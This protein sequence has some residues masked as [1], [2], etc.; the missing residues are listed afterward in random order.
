MITKYPPSF[1]GEYV[2]LGG[3]R[4]A[5]AELFGKAERTITTYTRLAKV[6][7]VING[8]SNEFELTEELALEFLSK[9]GK[10]VV[11]KD[12]DFIP[13]VR[14][15]PGPTEK[16]K[17]GIVSDTHLC[18]THQ[19]LTHLWD[20]YNQARQDGVKY[21]VHGGDMLAGN[22]VYTGQENE[23]FKW[24]GDAQVDY[25]IDKYPRFD[26]VTTY[27]IDG[28]HDLSFYAQAGQDIGRAIGEKRDDLVFCGQYA[29]MVNIGGL[30]I[31][32]QHGERG[33][34]YAVSYK[35]QKY[36]EQVPS[37]DKPHIVVL[38]HYHQAL[39]LP[40]YRNIIGILPGCFESQTLFL[41]RKAINPVIQGIIATFTVKR[42]GEKTHIERVQ[43]EFIP[44]YRP[45]PKDF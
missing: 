30:K 9:Q 5:L 29:G 7:G 8:K 16:I 42:K 28:N 13:T 23:I 14:V 3:N 26:G 25:C 21:F 38:G 35:L 33:A 15:D 31:L 43:F 1:P 24:G 22:K 10:T 19:Q 18:S 44:Y 6:A 4:K 20:F 11:I 32:L 17:V 36:L 45:I 27:F 12:E 39:M 34:S 37:E 2:R 41:K 40:P